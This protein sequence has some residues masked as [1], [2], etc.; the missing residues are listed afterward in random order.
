MSEINE[1]LSLG[2]SAENSDLAQLSQADSLIDR[3]VADPLDEGFVA[4]DHWSAA[5]RFGNTPAEMAQ[6]ETIDQRVAQE[7]PEPDGGPE[8]DWNPDGEKRQVGSTRAGRLV[9]PGGSTGADTEPQAVASDV[10]ISG[11]AASAEEAAM[12]VIDEEDLARH[13]DEDGEPAGVTG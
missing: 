5:Q 8:P 2:E 7:E 12:H 13:D 3:G 10:G 4:P 6:G 9:A 11:G 1:D